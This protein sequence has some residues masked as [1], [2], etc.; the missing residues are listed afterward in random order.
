MSILLVI[1]CLGLPI[2]ITIILLKRF[3]KAPNNNEDYLLEKIRSLEARIKALEEEL[4]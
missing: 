3:G 2:I 4:Y 1:I